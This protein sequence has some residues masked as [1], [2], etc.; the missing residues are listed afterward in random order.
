MRMLRTRVGSEKLASMTEIATEPTFGLPPAR[1]R[2]LVKVGL[3]LLAV[4]LLWVVL[5]LLGVDVRGWLRNLWDQ[6]KAIWDNNP[7]YIIFAL[8]FQ[9][10][11]TFFAGL[12]YYAVLKAAYR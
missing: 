3:W 7:G 12:S 4:A 10:G 11:Q 9:F 2:R 8:I 6:I 5:D 1:R